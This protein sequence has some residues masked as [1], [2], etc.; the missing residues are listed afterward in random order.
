[1]H[2]YLLTCWLTDNVTDAQDQEAARL[3]AEMDV[4]RNE[5]DRL[6]AVCE[7]QDA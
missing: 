1:M 2:V 3:Q 6:V 4:V 5:R 7:Q